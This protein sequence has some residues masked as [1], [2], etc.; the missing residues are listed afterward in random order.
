MNTQHLQY[1]IEIERTRS[2]SQAAE[3]LFLGQPNLSR[4]LHDMEQNLGF[5]IFERTSRGVR[6]TERGASFL[7]HARNVMREVDYIDA[8]G[9]RHAVPY[10][11]RVSIPRSARLLGMTAGYLAS[12][13]SQ[14]GLDAQIRECHA[15]Q[16]LQGLASG[17]TDIGI[18]RFRSEYAEYFEEQ[19]AEQDLNFQILDKFKYQLLFP[20]DH[21]L[22]QKASIAMA[23]L[24]GY[25]EIAHGDN[26]RLRSKQEE[27]NRRK[28]QALDRQA[29]L[30]LLQTIWGAYLWNE[31]QPSHVLDHWRLVQKP[32]ADN[33]VTYHDAL[34]YNPQ[35]VTTDIQAGFL[36]FVLG[37][38]QI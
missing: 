30:M 7:Q 38:S 37:Q 14:G 36:R 19:A 3:N 4:I 20:V 27:A 31:Q 8:L 25:T 34:L 21:P 24:E 5:R 28:I 26:F 35:Y 13:Q 32:C 11:L 22:A 23:D 2:I 29:Q 18:I 10:R 17:E 1:I 6:P 9:P 16:T 33:P 15:R 12:F